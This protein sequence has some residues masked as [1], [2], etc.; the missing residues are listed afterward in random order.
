M[1]EI[2]LNYNPHKFQKQIHDDPAR[3]KVVVAGRRFGKSVFA[4]MHILLNA[5]YVPGLYWIV[6]PTYKQGKMIHWRELKKEV[7]PELITYKN[8]Q[9]LSIELVNGSRIEIKGAD[10]ENSL[11]GVGIKGVVFDETADQQPHVFW[12]II[13]PT[14][15]DSEGWAIFIGTP[16]GFNWFY[17]LYLKGKEGTKEKEEGWSSYK[18][19]SYDN[20]HL[21]PKEIDEAKR[22]TDEDSFAQEYMSEFKKFKGLIYKN[23]NRETHVIEPFEIPNDGEWEIYR[24]VDFGYGANPTVC[25]WIAVAPD[26]KWYVIDEYHD[27]KEV[28]DYHCGIILSKSAQYP[29]SQISW[30]DPSN[31][32]LIKEWGLKGVYL[33]PARRTVELQGGQTNLTQW[34]ATGINMIQ[35]KLKVSVIDQKPQL[36]IFK[37]CE[38]IIKEFEAYEWEEPKNELLNNPGRPKKANDHALDALRY[39]ACSYTGRQY[40]VPPAD[41]K[42]WSFS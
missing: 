19:T 1:S 37:N 27:I 35:E 39:F 20:P 29:S 4:R 14:L 34:V 13:R 3:F 9:E 33:T 28:S 12:D 31:S 25:L 40:Y 5:L 18:F 17:D 7:P 42:N 36:F 8:E 11:R 24:A 38:Y 21:N 32:M 6:N 15:V 26:N 10:N 2:N 41:N 23:F 22:A 16:R 30:G